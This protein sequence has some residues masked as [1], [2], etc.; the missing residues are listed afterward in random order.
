MKKNIN[1]GKETAAARLR[2]Q[3]V[4]YSDRLCGAKSA[5]SLPA[6][7][8]RLLATMIREEPNNEGLSAVNNIQQTD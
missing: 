5:T 8:S 1:N 6:E 3:F 4:L 2:L 7:K